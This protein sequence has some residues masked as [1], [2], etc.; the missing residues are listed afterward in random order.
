[1]KSGQ[2]QPVCFRQVRNLPIIYGL[3]LDIYIR[4]Y[5]H[6]IE[7]QEA[8]M[9]VDIIP[10]P[11]REWCNDVVVQLGQNTPATNGQCLAIIE[12]RIETLKA[13]APR[14]GEQ[15][16]AWADERGDL[17]RIAANLHRRGIEP[18]PLHRRT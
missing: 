1:M 7:T 9:K 2:R 4:P 5:Y 12:A 15:R 10:I 17:E 16:I 3:T 8:Q 14:G 11:I 6:S 18:E 13:S